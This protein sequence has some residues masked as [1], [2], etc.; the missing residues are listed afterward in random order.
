M[1]IENVNDIFET[2]QQIL[3]EV[4]KVYEEHP[5]EATPL[6]TRQYI[7]AGGSGSQPH[8]CEQVTVSMGQTYTGMPGSP[9]ETPGGCDSPLASVFYVEVVR[10]TLTTTQASRRGSVTPGK[11]DPEDEMRLAK[12]QMQDARL[13]LEAGLRVGEGFLG[14]VADVSSGTES[15][16]YQAMILTVIT[17]VV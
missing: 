10:K 4:N 16:G 1:A 8:D 11:L 2:A 6:P 14:S 17:G 3:D 7:A 15:G 5:H 9:S 13:L 12:I